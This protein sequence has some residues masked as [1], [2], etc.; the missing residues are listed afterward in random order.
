MKL[1]WTVAD[2]VAEHPCL[3]KATICG[4]FAGRSSLTM[5]DILAL[6]TLNDE[7][8]VWMACRRGALSDSMYAAWQAAVL[9]RV[10]T[11]YA[12]PHPSTHAWAV[13][14]LDGTD[15]TAASAAEAAGAAGAACAAGAAWATG[16]AGAAW[17]TEYTQ[18][19]STLTE[20]LRAA[21]SG[22][23]NV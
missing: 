11:T 17:A 3:D 9:T 18:Q 22:C 12:L 4:H 14:W 15:R 21:P 1:F 7:Y 16:A 5:E 2:V 13:Q 23:D 10:I 19:V 20:L 8:K 6:P